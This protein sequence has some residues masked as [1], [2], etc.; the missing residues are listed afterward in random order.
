[1]LNGYRVGHREIHKSVDYF[2]LLLLSE[3]LVHN[4]ACCDVDYPHC[5]YFFLA[6]LGNTSA[7][8]SAADAAASFPPQVTCDYGMSRWLTA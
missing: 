4:L 3:I 5:Y 8:Y 1:M 6:V 2:L 7:A